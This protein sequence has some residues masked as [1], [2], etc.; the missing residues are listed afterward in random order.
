MSAINFGLPTSL[1]PD[2]LK[3]I[4]RYE[5]RHWKAL[6]LRLV[7]ECPAV[8]KGIH[9]SDDDFYTKLHA[10]LKD[11]ENRRVL[12]AAAQKEGTSKRPLTLCGEIHK[13]CLRSLRNDPSPF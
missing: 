5:P 7:R 6:E 10:L 8:W 3:Q 2:M 11:P 9:L 1:T 12:E 4:L 13:H